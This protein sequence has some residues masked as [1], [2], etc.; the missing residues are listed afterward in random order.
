MSTDWSQPQQVSDVLLAFPANVTGTLLPPIEVIPGEFRTHAHPLCQLASS[1]F[2]EGG[3]ITWNWNDGID[4]V[5]GVRHLQAVLRSF[6]PKHEHKI[7][8]VAYLLS[9]WTDAGKA[10]QA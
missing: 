6:E 1:L 7:A 5:S 8:G 4:G 2:F 3:G 10:R 9:R